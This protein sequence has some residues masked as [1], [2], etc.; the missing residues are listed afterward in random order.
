MA[1]LTKGDSGVS[2]G[3]VANKKPT[4]LAPL[5]SSL[6]YVSSPWP[7]HH[8]GSLRSLSNVWTTVYGQHWRI[9][10][11]EALYMLTSTAAKHLGTGQKTSRRQEEEPKSWGEDREWKEQRQQCL[12][13]PPAS[14]P[15]PATLPAAHP[16]AVNGP[17]PATERSFAEVA[18]F[19]PA[20]TAKKGARASVSS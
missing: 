5:H 4:G 15:K 1:S 2:G 17:A 19:P 18:A 3:G 12:D 11:G 14:T 10:R 13:P 8:P 16:A 20:S 9:V 6:Q 7:L